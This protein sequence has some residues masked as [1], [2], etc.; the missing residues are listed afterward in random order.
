MMPLFSRAFSNVTAA[1]L[2]TLVGLKPI[3]ADIVIPN[4]IKAFHQGDS[5]TG[6]GAALQV[7]NGSGMSK[8]DPNDPSTWTVNS[9]AWADD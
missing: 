8:P 5:L 2:L 1:L 9:T 3:S 4:S 6:N 7:I